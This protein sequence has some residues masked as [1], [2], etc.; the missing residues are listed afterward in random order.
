MMS[1]VENL[2]LIISSQLT[3]ASHL[4]SRSRLLQECTK[5]ETRKDCASYK[6]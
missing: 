4:F 3:K 5:N 1:K 6:H 2:F